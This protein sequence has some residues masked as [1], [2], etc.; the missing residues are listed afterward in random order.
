M[1]IFFR[2]ILVILGFAL[3]F[4]TWTAYSLE[5]SLEKF[6]MPQIGL[7]FARTPEEME[8]QLDNLTTGKERAEGVQVQRNILMGRLNKALWGDSLVFIPIYTALFF[9]LANHL[10]LSPALD[11]TRY[12]YFVLTGIA[13]AAVSDWIENYFIWKS[14]QSDAPI[15]YFDIKYYACFAKWFMIGAAVFF[16]SMGFLQ[17]KKFGIAVPGFINAAILVIGVILNPLLVQAGFGML[18]ILLLLTAIFL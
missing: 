11:G 9:A 15:A 4:M 5:R 6:F 12:F 18:G 3:V 8:E 2:A 10:R 7:E 14:L 13:I 17:L 16:T 1:Q